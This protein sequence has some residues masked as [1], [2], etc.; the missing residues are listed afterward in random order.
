MK[1]YFSK[2]SKFLLHSKFLTVKMYIQL[3]QFNC[4][5]LLILHTCYP[6]PTLCS[7]YICTSNSMV[8]LVLQYLNMEKKIKDV[9]RVGVYKFAKLNLCENI[10]KFTACY[11]LLLVHNF[12]Q[13]ITCFC[14]CF[15]ISTKICF[16][17]VMKII[18]TIFTIFFHLRGSNSYKNQNS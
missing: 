7:K 10:T 8:K 18:I 2:L 9:Q 1:R 11:N 4:P 5:R 12:H 17:R 3:G 16:V 15:I 14:R 13:Q 6:F